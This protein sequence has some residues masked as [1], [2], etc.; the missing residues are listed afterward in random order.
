MSDNGT[1]LLLDTHYWIWEQLGTPG[2]ITPRERAAIDTAAASG[3]LLLSVMSVWEVG[4]LESKGRLDL[5]PSC[6]EWV[7]RAL[8]IPGMALA[9]LRPDIALEA[10]RLPGSFHNDPADRI[11]VATARRMRARLMTKDQ[12]ILGY[13]RQKHVLTF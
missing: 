9:P 10:T 13:A 7:E 5:N 3:R 2:T 11:I 8:A 1:P 6:E 12:R 4:M